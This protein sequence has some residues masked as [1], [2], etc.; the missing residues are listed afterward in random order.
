MTED[1]YLQLFVTQ[2]CLR[3]S[4]GEN[5]IYRNPNREGDI[6]I[7]DFKGLYEVFPNLIGTKKNYSTVVFNTTKGAALLRKL[8]NRMKMLPCKVNDIEKYNPL[9]CQHTWFSD[10]RLNFFAD[11]D[12]EP[13]CAIEKWTTPAKI[14]RNSVRRKFFNALPLV[15]RRA[16]KRRV[17]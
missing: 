10:E 11:F 4:C 12:K 5:C 9:F 13:K 7:G 8:R 14:Y 2:H 16:I 15:V 3:E 6:T 1:R 17:K